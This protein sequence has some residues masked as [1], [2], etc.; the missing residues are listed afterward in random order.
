MGPREKNKKKMF[1][2][3]SNGRNGTQLKWNR[4]GKNKKTTSPPPSTGKLGHIKK[5]TGE[6]KKKTI[7]SNRAK[8]T[9]NQPI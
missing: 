6:K 4:K 7:T 9:E 1:F 5:G 3:T 8:H 2:P